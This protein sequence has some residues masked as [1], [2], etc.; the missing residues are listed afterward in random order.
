MTRS[1]AALFR[2]IEVK[3]AAKC[4]CMIIG[5]VPLSI[6]I[7]RLMRGLKFQKKGIYTVMFDVDK[8]LQC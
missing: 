3:Y 5:I 8:R 6:S 7:K 1:R 4:P 2:S